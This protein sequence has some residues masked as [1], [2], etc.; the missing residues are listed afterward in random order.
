MKYFL[1]ITVFTFLL[2]ANVGFAWNSRWVGDAPIRWHSDTNT[3]GFK[4]QASS[5]PSSSAF[6][7]GILEAISILNQNPSNI[8]VRVNPDTEWVSVG[9][10]QNEIW[11]TDNSLVT[12]GAPAI[13]IAHFN[14][15]AFGVWN[16]ME[17]DVIFNPAEVYTASRTHFD[18]WPY[19]GPFRPIQ[20]TALHELGHAMGMQHENRIYNIMG[21]DWTH[22]NHSS[23][24]IRATRGPDIG[25]G[26]AR[27][28][29]GLSPAVVDLSIS[30]FKYLGTNGEYSTH[31][32]T[33]FR[34]A[35][36]TDPV[37]AFTALGTDTQDPNQL[38]FRVRAN[39]WVTAEFTLENNGLNTVSARTR[40]VL[41]TNRTITT[42]DRSLFEQRFNFPNNRPSTLTVLLRI[43]A[44][45]PSGSRWYIG[46]IVDSTNTLIETTKRNNTSY[47]PIEVR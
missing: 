9:N 4:I 38:I 3:V 1:S 15:F 42:I 44:D 8:R 31:Q 16:L 11:F 17:T 29:G 21:E 36:T 35:S 40:F 7:N 37:E 45:L 18:T 28:Y 47:I 10:G 24:S 22:I 41:S 27:L 25:S 12:T 33:T 34:S 43:P 39:Q 2:Q 20:T 13:C 5:I 26:L 30:N 46:A 19:N 23:N 32:R 14:P 6:R